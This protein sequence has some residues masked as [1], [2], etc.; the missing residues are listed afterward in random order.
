VAAAAATQVSGASGVFFDMDGRRGEPALQAALSML[1]SVRCLDCGEIYSKPGDGGTAK[2]NPGCPNCG[3]VGWLSV[4][5][6]GQPPF[7][8]RHSGADPQPGQHAH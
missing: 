8:R 4:S 7:A 5:L 1:V 6:P 2:Q 3:Y